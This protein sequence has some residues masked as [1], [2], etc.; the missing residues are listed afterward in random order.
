MSAAVNLQSPGACWY[1][2][3]NEGTFRARQA[4]D[5]YINDLACGRELGPYGRRL[6]RRAIDFLRAGVRAID[7]QGT[8]QKT[9]GWFAD[10]MPASE[11]TAQRALRDL[12]PRRKD[13]PEAWS[14]RIVH[15]Q[16]MHHKRES[17]TKKDHKWNAPHW[18]TFLV[19]SRYWTGR[20]PGRLLKLVTGPASAPFD[21]HQVIAGGAF[22]LPNKVSGGGDRMSP[23]QIDP[24]SG[25]SVLSETFHP[26]TDLRTPRA[27]AP[28]K[29]PALSSTPPPTRA[30][31]P[32]AGVGVSPRPPA[33]LIA[34]IAKLFPGYAGGAPKAIARLQALG[35]SDDA[36]ASYL[37]NATRDPAVQKGDSPLFLAVWRAET[38]I[39]KPP[40]PPK[41]PP[42]HAP[43]ARQGTPA[44]TVRESAAI[45]L[46]ENGAAKLLELLR[47]RP[48]VQRLGN[49]P[50]G[51]GG[52]PA[53]EK[54]AGD[55]D[56]PP[57]RFVERDPTDEGGDDDDS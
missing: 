3:Q 8:T 30:D 1:R 5:R 42:T 55:D 52:P 2:N 53:E 50:G 43:A 25:S 46:A 11:R 7:G 48:R 37:K 32:A 4:A 29:P 17:N 14:R 20:P 6:P 19:P 28:P 22:V 57:R 21:A 40:L 36:I 18:L 49:V 10:R 34:L 56:A 47:T 23:K 39:R 9:I 51:G 33:A 27:K 31:A 41:P 12:A 45:K 13:H 44:R 15:V 26:C 35:W 38:E 54:P 16:E 24:G